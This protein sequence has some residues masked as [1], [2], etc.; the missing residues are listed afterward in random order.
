MHLFKSL[1]ISVKIVKKKKNVQFTWN[2]LYNPRNILNHITESCYK[3]L[4]CIYKWTL[5]R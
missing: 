4:K 2:P 5:L 3:F 1:I